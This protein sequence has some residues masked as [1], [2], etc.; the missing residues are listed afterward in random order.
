MRVNEIHELHNDSKYV[1]APN[2]ASNLLSMK[3]LEAQF[4]EATGKM[5]EQDV[6]DIQ[7]GST[8]EGMPENKTTLMV[9]RRVLGQMRFRS[10]SFFKSDDPAETI[11]G[12]TNVNH[13][14]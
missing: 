10:R 8:P 6:L 9:A 4:E 2:A 13:S 3:E 12:E 7:R 14:S 11:E 1:V 5:S